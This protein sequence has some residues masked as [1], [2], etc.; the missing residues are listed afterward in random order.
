M[1]VWLSRI[2]ERID[3]RR[4]DRSREASRR[5]LFSARIWC[6]RC[7]ASTPAIAKA[8]S[9]PPKPTIKARRNPLAKYSAPVELCASLDSSAKGFTGLLVYRTMSPD[10]RYR[11]AAPGNVLA[12]FGPTA[13]SHVVT[14]C[15]ST[16]RFHDRIDTRL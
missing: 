13:R 7:A 10:D 12:G 4:W 6:S 8:R 9:I 3:A 14:S 5:I 1:Y 2:Y 15:D 16:N 11:K